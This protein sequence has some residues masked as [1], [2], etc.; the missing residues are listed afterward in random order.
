MQFNNT[1]EWHS[2][3]TYLIEVFFS[4][5]KLDEILALHITE[6]N[7]V[8]SGSSR[9]KDGRLCWMILPWGLA[10]LSLPLGWLVENLPKQEYY[11]HP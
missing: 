9:R 2:T 6:I 5:G 3:I 4:F 11:S 10:P 7:S 8:Y 1:R